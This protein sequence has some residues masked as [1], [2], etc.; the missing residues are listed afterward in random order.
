LSA[1]AWCWSDLEMRFPAEKAVTHAEPDFRK[2][3]LRNGH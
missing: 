2:G 1:D 3:V